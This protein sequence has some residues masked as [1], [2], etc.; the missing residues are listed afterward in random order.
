MLWLDVH[1]SDRPMILSTDAPDLWFKERGDRADQNLFAVVGTPDKMGSQPVGDMFGM[2]HIHTPHAH[3][4][5]DFSLLSRGAALPRD[6]SEG[7]PAA[8]S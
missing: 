2:L 1:R 3:M 4:C 7:Y 5:S 8:L 6:E